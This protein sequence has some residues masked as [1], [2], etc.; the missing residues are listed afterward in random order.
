MQGKHFWRQFLS[1]QFQENCLRELVRLSA[2]II[3]I[4]R[5]DHTEEIGNS[6]C[7]IIFSAKLPIFSIV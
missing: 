2:R 6:W 3:Q 5:N 7:E 1:L 4:H